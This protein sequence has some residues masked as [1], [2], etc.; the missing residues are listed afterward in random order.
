MTCIVLCCPGVCVA[1]GVPPAA[2]AGAG[3]AV[4]ELTDDRGRATRP[5]PEDTRD[6]GAGIGRVYVRDLG[7]VDPKGFVPL[8]AAAAAATSCLDFCA[9]ARDGRA[10][11][12]LNESIGGAIDREL[13]EASSPAGRCEVEA[14]AGY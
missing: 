14:V 6:R 2:R 13:S 9:A 11:A 1:G 10:D 5:K 7:I 4:S 12:E 3:V 8:D